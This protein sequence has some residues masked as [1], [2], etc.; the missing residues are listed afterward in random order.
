VVDS[1]STA[2]SHIISSTD[3][4]VIWGSGGTFK[5][6]FTQLPLL[7]CTNQSQQQRKKKKKKDDFGVYCTLFQQFLVL[8][9]YFARLALLFGFPIIVGMGVARSSSYV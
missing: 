7:C 8:E 6:F 2:I 4:T 5:S 3:L 1:L 9:A